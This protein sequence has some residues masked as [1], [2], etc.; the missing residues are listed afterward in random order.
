MTS[1]G[2][3]V[4]RNLRKIQYKDT[5]ATKKIIKIKSGTIVL[6]TRGGE[7]MENINNKL[8]VGRLLK[9]RKSKD[10]ITGY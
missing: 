8:K 6:D 5:D 9:Y 4:L 7:E 1:D 3:Q 2:K 10:K